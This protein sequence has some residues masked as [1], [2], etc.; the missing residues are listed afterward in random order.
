MEPAE[1]WGQT[2][3]VARASKMA[4][5]IPVGHLGFPWPENANS[6]RVSIKA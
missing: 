1:K 3:K 2:G 5:G 6:V 4:I